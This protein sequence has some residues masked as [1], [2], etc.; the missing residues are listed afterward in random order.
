MPTLDLGLVSFNAPEGWHFYPMGEDHVVGRPIGLALPGVLNLAAMRGRS[1]TPSLSHDD[2]LANARA[3][4]GTDLPPRGFDRAR[5]T[6]EGCVAG[7]ESF[8]TPNDFVR[9]WYYQCPNGMIVAWF[10]CPARRLDEPAVQALVR[11]CDVLIA[12]MRLAGC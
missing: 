10:G 9:L 5:D 3:A 6:I 4:V 12:S 8:R 7:G 1:L 11:Q 2:C